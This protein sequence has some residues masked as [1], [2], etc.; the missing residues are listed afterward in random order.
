MHCSCTYQH[1][2]VIANFPE[3]ISIFILI[4]L[5]ICICACSWTAQISWINRPGIFRLILEISVD[6]YDALHG[7]HFP[8][9]IPIFILLYLACFPFVPSMLP[10]GAACSRGPAISGNHQPGVHVSLRDGR[11][12]HGHHRG[13][14]H[15]LIRR[16]R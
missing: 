3:C 7:Y 14:L 12:A 6:T 15:A 9:S 4:L 16:H 13:R 8:E 11:H 10:D 5:S 1:D 2:K